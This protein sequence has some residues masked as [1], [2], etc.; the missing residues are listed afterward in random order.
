MVFLGFI[1][2]GMGWFAND[3]WA[4][5]REQKRMKSKKLK[6]LTE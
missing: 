6:G 1:C 5:H 3:V 4:Y 2:M